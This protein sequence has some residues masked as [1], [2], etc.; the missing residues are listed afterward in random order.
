MTENIDEFISQMKELRKNKAYEKA[1]Q[2]LEEL[3]RSNPN[4]KEVWNEL[5]KTYQ[6]INQY[7]KALECQEKA[8]SIDPVYDEAW[9]WRGI[10]LG[11]IGSHS[12]A[13][14][15]QEKAIDLN[16]N[17]DRAWY[18]K[19][20]NHSKL[21]E[22]QEAI[23]CYLKSS[24]MTTKQLSEDI[25]WFGI[26]IVY[27]QLKQYDKA[28]HF[29]EKAAKI[30]QTDESLWRTIGF[31]YGELEKY[32]KS[33]ESYEQALK[34]NSDN[35]MTLSSIAWV[36]RKLKSHKTAI[37]FA[38]K[39]IAINAQNHQA[40]FTKA[41]SNE[42]LNRDKT[43]IECYERAIELKPDDYQAW[44]NMGWSYHKLLRNKKAIEC[45]EKSLQISPSY[46]T[47]KA[48][49]KT[50]QN[51]GK[52]VAKIL[53]DRLDPSTPDEHELKK[54]W[55]N[56]KKSW[57]TDGILIIHIILFFVT[58][59]SGTIRQL[60]VI[61]PVRVAEFGEYYRLITFIFVYENPVDFFTVVAAIIDFFVLIGLI[62]SVG[63]NTEKNFPRWQYLLL[64]FAFAFIGGL[65]VTNYFP[66]YPSGPRFILWGLYGMVLFVSLVIKR[67]YRSL[68][69]LLF[70]A[71]ERAYF[72]FIRPFLFQMSVDSSF[73]LFDL[74]LD[75]AMLGMGFLL[76]LLLYYF[77]SRVLKWSRK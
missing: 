13:I 28:I 56:V 50:I 9:C 19:G 60:F 35:D 57:I 76:G 68:I 43:A 40:W 65:I 32:Q 33:L 52:K 10:H 25:A 59:F 8:I 70:L 63:S 47:A 22:H 27:K 23:Q 58:L 3:T 46:K 48:N 74:I 24:E 39:S 34:I 77:N 51:A 36:H 26:G 6:Q 53:V 45:F 16:P 49:L 64:Y 15:S 12:E 42:K 29:L 75:A 44:S 69:V 41:F 4:R 71:V 17:N 54:M 73:L 62:L 55:E 5:G 72:I 2:I 11:Y 38:E 66:D 1:I 61:D 30:N 20:W 67:Y 31:V 18:N 37:E 7:K 21:G 14:K